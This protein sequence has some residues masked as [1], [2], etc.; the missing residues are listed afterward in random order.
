MFQSRIDVI[1]LLVDPGPRQLG[2]TPT[3]WLESGT[4]LVSRIDV[5]GLFLD[6]EQELM[7]QS[8][9]DVILTSPVP[10]KVLFQF[11]FQSPRPFQIPPNESD[12]IDPTPFHF[13]V[14]GSKFHIGPR[15][16][17]SVGGRFQNPRVHHFGVNVKFRSE[18][19]AG[20]SQTFPDD[21][22]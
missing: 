2:W 8:R 14:Y 17:T 7:F 12:P 21:L 6:P 20:S 1:G 19:R 16:I 13:S 10:V 3:A 22:P 15:L 9:I 18:V 5:I 11:Q 4:E